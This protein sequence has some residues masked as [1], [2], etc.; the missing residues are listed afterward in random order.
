MSPER[1]LIS[2]RLAVSQCGWLLPGRLGLA[3]GHRRRLAASGTA[4]GAIPILEDRPV[5]LGSAEPC[6]LDRGRA[7][8]LAAEDRSIRRLHDRAIPIL[9][10]EDVA[11]DV[12]DALASSADHVASRVLLALRPGRRRRRHRG[13]SEEQQWPQRSHRPGSS[14]LV[15][16]T[17]TCAKAPDPV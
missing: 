2:A 17:G 7:L 5:L 1:E 13:K 15:L 12:D 11:S 16:Q 14:H 9:R 3:V 10:T 6:P 8:A 4:D